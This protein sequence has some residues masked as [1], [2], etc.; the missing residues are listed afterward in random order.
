[1]GRRPGP[2]G[3]PRQNYPI[4]RGVG[5]GVGTGIKENGG[6]EM[7]GAENEGSTNELFGVALGEGDPGAGVAGEG[8]AKG[9]HQNAGIGFVFKDTDYRCGRPF[10]VRLVGVA[11]FGTWQAVIFLIR[12]RRQNAEAV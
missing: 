12:Q 6:T 3:V 4:G 1:M 8:L 5:V 2:A 11:A 9:L 10:A 7:I